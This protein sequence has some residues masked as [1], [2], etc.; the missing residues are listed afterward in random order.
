MNF[1]RRF[2]S[3]AGSCN[4]HLPRAALDLA[5]RKAAPKPAVGFYARLCGVAASALLVALIAT[6][7]GEPVPDADWDEPFRVQDPPRRRRRRPFPK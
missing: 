1:L 3:P 4:T 2:S 7:G 5:C 6:S